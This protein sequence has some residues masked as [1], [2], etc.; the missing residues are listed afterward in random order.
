[1]VV[2][3][4]DGSEYTSPDFSA[5]IEVKETSGGGEV[6]VEDIEADDDRSTPGFGLIASLL[7]LT[8]L[9]VLRRRA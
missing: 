8:T 7:A 1:M 5:N 9:V 4:S 2:T 3:S 6:E